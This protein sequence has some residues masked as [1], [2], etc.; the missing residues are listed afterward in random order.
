LK[1][2]IVSTLNIFSS[3][4]RQIKPHFANILAVSENLLARPALTEQMLGIGYYRC[5]LGLALA[6]IQLWGDG[7]TRATY[8]VETVAGS[9]LIGDGGLAT[10]AQFSTI[11]GIAVDKAGN[12]YIADTG[13]HRVRKVAAG[14]V[15]TIAGTGVAGYSGD[16]GPAVNAQLNF[17][18]GLAVDASGNVF[19]ADYGNDRVRMIAPSGTIATIVGTGSHASSPDNLAPTATSLLSPRNVALDALGNLYISEFQGH[20]VRKC[21]GCQLPG[22]GSI[23]TVAGCGRSGQEAPAN[24][25]GDNGPA[26]AALLSFPA[27]MAFRLGQLLIADSGRNA[28]RQVNADGTIIT[29]PGNVGSQP[30]ALA[31]NS[32]GT[33]Y[34]GDFRSQAAL[35]LSLAGVVT[36]YA[37][38]GGAGCQAG[39]ACALL[40][41]LNDLAVDSFGALWIADGMQ[42]RKVDWTGTTQSVVA[43]DAYLSAVGDGGPATSANLYQPGGVTLDGAG[44]LYIAD[45]GTHRVRHVGTDGKMRTLAGTGVAGMGTLGGSAAATPLHSPTRV[46]MDVI[47]NVVIAER[48]NNRVLKVSPVQALSAVANSTGVQGES[49]DGTPPLSAQLNE[50]QAACT[51]RAGNQYLVDTNNHRVM[52]LPMGGV[53]QTVAGNWSQG[54]AGDGGPAQLAQLNTPGGCATD[55]TGNLYIADTYNHAIRMVTPAGII[56]TVA[57]TGG[58]AGGSGDEGSAAAAQLAFPAGVVVDDA[59]DLFIADTGNNRIRMVTPDGLIHGIAGTGA[60][61]FSG[62]DAPAASAKLN[63]PQGLFLD[64]AG[65]VYFADTYNNRIRRLVPDE[66]A[67]PATPPVTV[68]VVNALSLLPGAVAPGEVVSVFGTGIGPATAA[69]GA[70]DGTGTLPAALAGVVV[71]FNGTPAPLFYAQSGQINA[72]APYELAGSASSSVQV[73]VQGKL[74]GTGTVAVA[75]AAPALLTQASNQDGTQNAQS[76]PALRD[77]WMTFYAT[78]AGMTDSGNADGVPAA[79]PYAHPLLPVSLTIAGINADILFA[80]AAPGMIGMLQIDAVVPGGFVAPGQQPVVLTVGTAV[81]P[82][83]AI[84]IQ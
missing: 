44:N 39:S 62:E 72:Q 3:P 13:N 35:A 24:A 20:R 22:G 11:Q 34:V 50:P 41:G 36:T 4:I 58:A 40:T 76:N 9:S 52:K 37:G 46:T 14:V 82:S 26:T 81:S 28:I 48:L 74:V 73:L 12:L 54:F 53:L 6:S 61:A 59:G 42:V 63:G 25:I 43:G 77:T 15:T 27:G 31:A 71:Q 55:S 33:V 49:P 78:G 64:G 32:S 17:P 51:D 69:T 79:A 70:L 68:T 1:S 5:V 56:S 10:A 45:T 84:W 16:N 29:L 67:P 83:L 38:G 57:G 21:T 47:G 23:R 80:G 18:Y 30:I 65:N 66:Q 60:A 7:S 8:H 2:F 19:I 75:P